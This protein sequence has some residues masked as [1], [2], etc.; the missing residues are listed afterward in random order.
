MRV[1]NSAVAAALLVFCLIPLVRT[2]GQSAPGAV[3]QQKQNAIASGSATLPAGDAAVERAAKEMAEAALNFWNGLTPEQQAKCAFPFESEERFNWHFIP[4]ERRGI[5]WNDMTPAQQALAHAFL[6]SGLSNRGYQQA[7]T[8][9]SLEQVLK[10]LEQGKG[11]KRDAGN[12]AFSVYGTPGPHATWGWRFE[13]HHL[14]LNFTI[15][16]GRAVAGPVFFGTNPATVLDGPRKGLRVLAVEEDVGREV[17]KSLTD[18]QRKTAIYD[19]KS[20]N[21]I[22]TGNSRK[23][24]P[25]PPVGLAVSDMTAAQQKL[26]MTLVEHYAYRLRS[27][28]ADQD[29]AKIA[30]AGFKEIRFAWAGSLE[31]GQPHYYRLHGPTFL[32]EFDNTQNNANH[33]H[34]VWRDSA[35]DFGEDL[36]RAHYDSHKNDPGHGHDK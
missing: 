24:N 34:T 13:G 28:L 18:D 23:A 26:L 5:T 10:E 36:L 19:V 3:A 27:E 12:Y 11:P 8:I 32:V 17:V 21:E 1:H 35:N 22:I 29:L 25:G 31:P 16:D 14:S 4:R 9:M 33:I 7:E 2:S 6:A 15:V 20:P 30:A